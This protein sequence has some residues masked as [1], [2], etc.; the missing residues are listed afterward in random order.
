MR[1][2]LILC[3][4]AAG[5]ALHADVVATPSTE[6]ATVAACAGRPAQATK[7]RFRGA[8]T[9]VLAALGTPR[10]RG[11]DL[12]AVAGDE[13]QTIAGKVAYS[14]LDRPATAEYVD[15]FVCL[16]DGW[17]PLG[18]A[19]TGADGRFEHVLREA[20]RIPTGVHD[21]YGHVH[22]DGTGF[23]FL[24]YVA[25]RGTQVIV[26]DIDGTLTEGEHA[27]VN[28]V[29]FGD[30]IAHRPRAPQTLASLGTDIVYVSARGDQYTDV[31]RRWLAAHGFPRGPLRLARAH[32]LP[33]GPRQQAWKVRTLR[34]LR[35]PVAAAVG[36]RYTDIA[37]YASSGLRPAQILIKL[38]E[39]A[40]EVRP[41]LAARRAVGFHDYRELP[42]LVARAV[43]R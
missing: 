22:G 1:A 9:N 13:T 40:D 24:A 18:T 23:R 43:A 38:P 28:T 16:E 3:L 27:I 35:V 37:A 32:L 21:L 33:A 4:A 14:S 19:V 12:I 15:L 29:L 25:A 31:T 6:L 17:S 8:G 41:A 34:E 42:A 7:G 5:C 20:A 36:N 30:D 10:H 26:A 39:F 11:V 2:V